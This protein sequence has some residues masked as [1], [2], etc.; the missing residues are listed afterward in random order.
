[1]VARVQVVMG[2]EEGVCATKGLLRETLCHRYVL[3]L[4]DLN[5]HIS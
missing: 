4:H 3:C 5:L 1:V 2:D